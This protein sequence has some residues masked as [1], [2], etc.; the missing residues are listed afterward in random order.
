MVSS[1][2]SLKYGHPCSR[3]ND[4]GTGPRLQCHLPQGLW[5]AITPNPTPFAVVAYR[6]SLQ[7]SGGMGG[8]L[9]ISVSTFSL[10]GYIIRY[11][12]NYIPVTPSLC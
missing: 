12:R 9:C 2:Q 10:F 5:E 3:C 4:H 11:G 6:H 7:S 1:R 8:P